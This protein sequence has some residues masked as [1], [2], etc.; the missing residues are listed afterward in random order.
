[1]IYRCVENAPPA[2]PPFKKGGRKLLP[3]G[4][5]G[6]AK[7]EH[8]RRRENEICFNIE[9]ILRPSA[10]AENAPKAIA[11][12]REQALFVGVLAWR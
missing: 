9:V 11:P 2:G 5:M 3:K 8:E 1:L 12:K 7:A 4:K 10:T 6:V